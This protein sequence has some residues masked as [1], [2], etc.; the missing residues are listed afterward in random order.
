MLLV[1]SLPDSE[2]LRFLR[3]MHIPISKLPLKPNSLAD[4]DQRKRLTEE[5]I[6]ARQLI[7]AWIASKEAGV[8]L[9]NWCPDDL[10]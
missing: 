3:W 1:A 5:V 9:V 4:V 7:T 10:C 8:N 6:G 2:R